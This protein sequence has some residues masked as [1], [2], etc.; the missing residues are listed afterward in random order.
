[1]TSLAPQP[2]LGNHSDNHRRAF[3]LS[4]NEA[5]VASGKDQDYRILRA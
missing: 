4:Y 5:T 1:M 2:K 3:I